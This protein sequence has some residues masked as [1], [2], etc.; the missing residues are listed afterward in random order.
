M[1]SKTRC[2]K[3][4]DAEP[5]EKLEFGS[6]VHEPLS[7]AGIETVGQLTELCA[8]GVLDIK[9]IGWSTL[10]DIIDTLHEA[11]LSLNKHCR[12]TSTATDD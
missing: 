1:T 2:A 9:H 3:L 6:W 10:L 4:T 7:N 5:I 12:Q 8:C 11:G